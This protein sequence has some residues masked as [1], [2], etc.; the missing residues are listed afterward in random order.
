MFNFS[1]GR[2]RILP[3]PI[4]GV[5][6][7]YLEL[8][9]VQSASLEL[10][11][12]LK[13]LRGAYRYPIAVADGKGTASGKVTF[14]QLWPN[15]LNAILSGT[16]SNPTT[17]TT[18]S[19]QPP[20]AIVGEAHS[21]SAGGTATL[22]QAALMVTGS[23]VITVLDAT[24]DAVFYTRTTG[25]AVSSSIGGKTAG[26]YT[27]TAGVLTFASADDNLNLLA[28]YQYLP[29]AATSINNDKIA[30]AQIGMNN[31]PTFQLMLIGT[32]AKNIY[33][34]TAQQFIVQLNACL[35]PSLKMDF[36]L[37][38]FTMADLDYQAF[39]DVNGNLGNIYMINPGG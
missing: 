24:G 4:A 3:P 20:V 9:V 29:V 33:N 5:A 2:A 38:D 18:L 1:A 7:S 19:P 14:A 30:L 26:T 36:K 13:E 16:L 15:T 25:T 37:D 34:S 21:I 31:A 11:V 39:I 8:G 23:E 10:K 32:G 27:I 28:S 35:A 12:D 22:T 6:Q 17:G